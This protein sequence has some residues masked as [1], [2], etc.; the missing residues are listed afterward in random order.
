LEVNARELAL[1]QSEERLQQSE[2]KYRRLFEFS[3]DPTWLI[4]REHFVTTNSAACRVV[5]FQS[6]GEVLNRRMEDLS[7][8]TCQQCVGETMGC[9]VF[10]I[11]KL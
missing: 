2:E 1:Q 6:V 5:G 10:G 7:P 8:P 4:I 11:G 3:E 9:S